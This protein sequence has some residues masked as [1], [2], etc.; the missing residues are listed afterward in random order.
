MERK[1]F[2]AYVALILGV[3]GINTAV[4][5]FVGFINTAFIPDDWG[6]ATLYSWGLSLIAYLA[7][8]VTYVHEDIK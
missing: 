6:R 7:Y 4:F 5:C 1:F 2:R 8:K 3:T